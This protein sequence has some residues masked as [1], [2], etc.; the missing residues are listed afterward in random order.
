[1]GRAE[2][3]D[4]KWDKAPVSTPEFDRIITEDEWYEFQQEELD[5]QQEEG[6]DVADG[7]EWPVDEYGL[8]YRS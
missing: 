5:R 4:N 2:K 1:M 6:G 7:E 3:Q 8:P